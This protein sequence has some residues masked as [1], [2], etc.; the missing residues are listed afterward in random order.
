ML[1]YV[2][3]AGTP[4]PFAAVYDLGVIQIFDSPQP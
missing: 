2:T 4:G 1:T 3:P